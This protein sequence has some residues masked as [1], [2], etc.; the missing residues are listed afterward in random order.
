MVTMQIQGE[1]ALLRHLGLLSQFIKTFKPALENIADQI[2]NEEKQVFSSGGSFDGRKAWV[3][4]SDKYAAR[5]NKIAPGKPILRL[6]DKLY[7][8]ATGKDGIYEVS[9]TKMETGVNL[10]YARVHQYGYSEKNIPARPYL[11]IGKT[12]QGKWNAIMNKYIYDQ[13]RKSGFSVV[14]VGV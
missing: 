1:E 5:K 14:R 11:T 10:P 13:S 2:H 12:Q 8:Q 4:L 7:K 6:T 3:K 9:D